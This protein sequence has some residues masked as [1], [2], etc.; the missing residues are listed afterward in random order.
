MKTKIRYNQSDKEAKIQ[1][2][3]SDV[4]EYLG[5]AKYN[6]LVRGVKSEYE[7]Y[8]IRHAVRIN[9]VYCL[10]AGIEGFPVRAIL[11]I[12]TKGE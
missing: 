3:L 7:Y 12:A 1:A 6:V 8:G 9:R 11:T 5:E 2:A 10:I 4:K